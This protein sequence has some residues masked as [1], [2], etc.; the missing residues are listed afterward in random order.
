[1]FS[2]FKVSFDIIKYHWE[3]ELWL[4][5]TICAINLAFITDVNKKGFT[6]STHNN[7]EGISS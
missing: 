7:E 5:V 6:L 2:A 4:N 3:G 1:M